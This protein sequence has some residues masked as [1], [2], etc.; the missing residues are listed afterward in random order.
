MLSRMNFGNNNNNNHNHN[1]SNSRHRG[2]SKSRNRENSRLCYY[3]HRFGN[4]AN[5]CVPPCNFSDS[6]K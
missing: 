3:H 5:K 1:R 6:P 4:K 2:R